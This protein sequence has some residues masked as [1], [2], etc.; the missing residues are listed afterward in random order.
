MKRSFFKIQKY[1]FLMFSTSLFLENIKEFEP[2]IRFL[3][4]VFALLIGWLISSA[5]GQVVGA[6]LNKIKVNQ[7]LKKMGW[8]E[9]FL[10]ADIRLDAARFFG[11][12]VKWC[13]II[14]VLMLVVEM[15]GL[16]EFSIFLREVIREWFPNIIIS[17][18]IFVTAVV[19][20]DFLSRVIAAS[21]EKAKMSYSRLLGAGVRW[22]I[23]VFAVLAIFL[24][25]GIT[26]DIIKAIIYGL[27]AM[28]ALAGGLAFG[29]G[30]KDLAAEILKELK[31]KIR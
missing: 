12:L 15:V 26:P 18:L 2:I 22:A 23:W 27:I 28:I 11:D 25:L 9:A 7:I 14:I 13:G 10:K 8:E 4:A 31:D 29:L 24:Q 21:A 16:S 30:G 1:N 3:I 6:L 20:A 17:C 5:G 19:L